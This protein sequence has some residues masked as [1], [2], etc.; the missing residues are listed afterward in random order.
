MRPRSPP[1]DLLLLRRSSLVTLLS[2]GCLVGCSHVPDAAP[3]MAVEF[4]VP[5]ATRPS[6][7]EAPR[8]AAVGA[9]G[10][11]GAKAEALRRWPS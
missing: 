3:R 7:V 9:E 10:A 5:A 4:P 1:E 11:L 8:V 6:T 2:L